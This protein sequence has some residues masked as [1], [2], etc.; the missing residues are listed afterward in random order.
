MF[1]IVSCYV[2]TM[3]QKIENKKINT[4]KCQNKIAK[5]I[6][7]FCTSSTNLYLLR[8]DWNFI[9]KSVWAEYVI[10]KWQVVMCSGSKYLPFSRSI[11]KNS[12]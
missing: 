5:N 3:D 10:R 4:F 6:N 2:P 9:L 1:I 7:S 12:M 11:T 8:C